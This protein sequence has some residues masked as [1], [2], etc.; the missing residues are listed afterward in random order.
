[1][2]K[3]LFQN[4]DPEDWIGGDQLQLE[5]TKESLSCITDFS[6]DINCV[7]N[8]DIVHCFNFTMPWTKYQIWNAIK[9]NKKIVCSMIYHEMDDYVDYKIQQAM[10]NEL[11]ACIFL[12]KGELERARRHLTIPDEKI[13]FIPNGIDPWWFEKETEPILFDVLTVGRIDENKAQLSVAKACKELG[14]SY[15]CIGDGGD[16]AV[17]VSAEGAVIKPAM[18]QKELRRYYAG[19]KIFALVS[20]K[21]LMPLTV[22]EAG[23]QGKPIVLTTGC[24]WEIPCFRAEYN[25][26]SSIKSA[27]TKALTE[28]YNDEFRVSLRDMTWDKVAK[29]LIGIYESIL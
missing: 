11:D 28:P 12:T 7:I 6:Y 9:Q 26:V 29:Q 1:M 8:S 22:M 4:R 20:Y 14:L 13:H 27:L 16:Y 15:C 21:E 17:M 5:R 3:V 23:A 24:E 19:C 2:I 18:P 25:N 10:V